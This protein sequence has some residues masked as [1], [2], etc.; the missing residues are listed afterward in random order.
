LRVEPDHVVAGL[1]EGDGE[2]QADVSEADY[3]DLHLRE[4]R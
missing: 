4:C 2:R 3:P 1:G